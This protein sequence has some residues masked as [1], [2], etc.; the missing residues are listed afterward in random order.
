MRGEK[1]V[2][3]AYESLRKVQTIDNTLIH[4]YYEVKS[5]DVAKMENHPWMTLYG[6]RRCRYYLLI[7]Q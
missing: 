6:L 1:N 5:L 7:S 2:H 4:K 3:T